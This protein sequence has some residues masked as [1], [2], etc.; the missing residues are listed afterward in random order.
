MEFI[1][2]IALN[3]VAVGIFIV[4]TSVGLF[5]PDLDLKMPLFKH[6]SIVTHSPILS[7]ILLYSMKQSDI[8]RFFI[9][10]FT[11]AV[12][13]HLVFDLYPKAWQGFAM[14][15]VPFY[16]KLNR[17]FSKIA[18]NLG[19]AISGGICFY[20]ILEKYELFLFLFALVFFFF[21]YSKKEKKVLLPLINIS[22]IFVGIY[23]LFAYI[24]K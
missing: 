16:G 2:W 5:Y 21:M 15:D 18:L 19:V 6:R 12:A 3:I 7:I 20:L 14:I 10:G 1:Q 11:M 4:A 9:V 17:I 23:C 13:I 22:V 8:T 24:L